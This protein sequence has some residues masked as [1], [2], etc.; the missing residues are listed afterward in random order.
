MSTTPATHKLDW[1]T[2]AVADRWSIFPTFRSFRASRLPR[3]VRD[4][5]I[6][7]LTAP[8]EVQPHLAHSRVHVESRDNRRE[9]HQRALEALTSARRLPDDIPRDVA[10]CIA[11]ACL[12]PAYAIRRE[13]SY[14]P[15]FSQSA[16][17]SRQLYWVGQI[18]AAV[19]AELHDLPFDS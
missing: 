14:R 17:L 15:G 12:I 4:V 7:D 13:P 10:H 5:I 1:L 16:R 2:N 8:V 19:D 3:T 6:A 18:H 9:E 11:D